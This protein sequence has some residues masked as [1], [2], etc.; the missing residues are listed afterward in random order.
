MLLSFVVRTFA[1]S[2]DGRMWLL[3]LTPSGWL[4]GLDP[5]ADDHWL[6]LTPSLVT[7]LAV[8]ALAVLARGRRDA[9]AGL[10]HVRDAHRPRLWLLGSAA[11]YG[12]RA[13]TGTLAAWAVG[14]AV[15]TAMLGTMVTSIADFIADDPSPAAGQ[16]KVRGINVSAATG[17]VAVYLTSATDDISSATPAIPALVFGAASPYVSVPPGTYRIR[18]TPV[19]NP[20]EILADAPNVVLG[21]RAVRTLLVTDAPGGGLPTTLSIIV[22]NN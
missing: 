1:N 4:D 13:T 12:W 18:L 6:G 5:F 8:S 21:A 17:P 20:S 2:S 10:L 3:P 7:A 15:T 14:C 16:V 11:A 22:D 19:G 9:G